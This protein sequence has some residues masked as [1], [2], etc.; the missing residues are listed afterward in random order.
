MAANV[1]ACRLWF[2]LAVS[3][4][5][6]IYISSVNKL[7]CNYLSCLILSAFVN[8]EYLI[9]TVFGPC[10]VLAVQTGRVNSVTDKLPVLWFFAAAR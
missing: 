5:S 6:Y 9:I 7:F 3:C 10:P 2:L 8:N 1:I 4:R